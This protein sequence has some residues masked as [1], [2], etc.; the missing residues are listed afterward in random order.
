MAFIKSLYELTFLPVNM[1]QNVETSLNE[2]LNI[3]LICFLCQFVHRRPLICNDSRM[4]V[5]E[6]LE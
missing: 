2:R 4:N 5:K 3:F 6:R 1:C